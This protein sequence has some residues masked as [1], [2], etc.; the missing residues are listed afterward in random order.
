MKG[1]EKRQVSQEAS[2]EANIRRRKIA[3]QVV[4]VRVYVK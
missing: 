3:Q 2:H 1:Y 4:P